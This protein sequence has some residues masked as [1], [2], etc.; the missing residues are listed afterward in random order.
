MLHVID[1]HIPTKEQLS[2]DSTNRK[3]THKIA[4]S[5]IKNL[6]K[7][8]NFTT[9][10]TAFTILKELR[11]KADYESEIIDWRKAEQARV[12]ASDILSIFNKNYP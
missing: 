11:L 7:G 10:K 1:V 9:F 8:G 3:A 5:N 12:N 6:L 4:E 2:E